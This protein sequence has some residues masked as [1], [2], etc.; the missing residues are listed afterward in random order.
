MSETTAKLEE[1]GYEIWGDVDPYEN[2][3]GPFYL[4]DNGD[5]TN[6]SAFISEKRHTNNSGA[7]HGGLLMSFADFALFAIARNDLDGNCVTV[8]F[9]SEFISAVGAGC[10]IE[11]TGEVLRATRSLIFVRGK[12]F[13]G[14]QTLMSFS[15]V[16]K[17]IGKRAA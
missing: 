17:K 6:R 3:V 11:A 14:Q 16:L 1:E 8:G 10:R 12:I 15:G 4:K 5:G 9:N 7:L 13:S 2:M